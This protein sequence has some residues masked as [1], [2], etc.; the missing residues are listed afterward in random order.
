MTD[1]RLDPATHD[2]VIQDGDLVLIDTEEYLCEQSVKV[3]LK[4]FAGE[5]FLHTDFGVPWLE[6]EEGS[7]PLLG[8]S[9]QSY[10]DSAIKGAILSSPHVLEI[11]RYESSFDAVTGAR[12]TTVEVLSRS[13]PITITDIRLPV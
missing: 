12:D 7:N 5:F 1:L 4:T 11:I 13:G 8:K 9:S 10:V 6:S 2:L 3:I